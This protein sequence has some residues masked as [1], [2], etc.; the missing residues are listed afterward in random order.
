[1]KTD[2]AQ[3]TNVKEAPWFDRMNAFISSG[4]P[5]SAVSYSLLI[6]DITIRNSIR[7]RS[8]TWANTDADKVCRALLDL[9]L[10]RRGLSD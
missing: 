4:Y 7:G 2:S 1:M 6:K 3:R 9:Q 5:V 8:D 10:Q